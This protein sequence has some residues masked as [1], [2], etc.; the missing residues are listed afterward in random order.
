MNMP[1]AHAISNPLVVLYILQGLTY[2]TAAALNWHAN[3]KDLCLCYWASA[4]LHWSFGAFHLMN[5]G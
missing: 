5:V 3:Q 2:A 1:L 4:I